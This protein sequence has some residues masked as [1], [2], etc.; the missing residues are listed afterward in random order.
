MSNLS[1][2]RAGAGQTAAPRRLQKPTPP[3]VSR[4]SAGQQAPDGSPS[5]IRERLPMIGSGS[6]EL[7]Q[8]AFP[9]RSQSPRSMRRAP[10]LEMIASPWIGAPASSGPDACFARVAGRQGSPPRQATRLLPFCCWV[11]GPPRFCVAAGCERPA[12]PL[13]AASRRR[14][15]E[16]WA[17]ERAS[18]AW[19]GR[20]GWIDDNW[21]GSSGSAAPSRSGAAL[22]LPGAVFRRRRV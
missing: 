19:G 17:P 8:A 10:G 14:R 16:P 3:G 22:R 18:D 12:M 13:R 5:E 9:R 20:F 6:S 11:R 4:T 7:A 21:C 1:S 2:L 15:G